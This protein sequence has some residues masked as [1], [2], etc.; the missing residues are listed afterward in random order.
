[1]L[2]LNP[3]KKRAVTGT[4][5]ENFENIRNEQNLLIDKMI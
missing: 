4:D 5:A 2:K 3:I 1:M